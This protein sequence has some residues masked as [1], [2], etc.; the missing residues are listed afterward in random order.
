MIN[1]VAFILVLIVML[2]VAWCAYSVGY[3]Q[4]KIDGYDEGMDQGYNEG[5]AI[6]GGN[7]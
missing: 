4:G 6:R 2:I 3:D 7:F 5:W 1:G